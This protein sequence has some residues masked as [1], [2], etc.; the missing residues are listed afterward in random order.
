M[1]KLAQEL[2]AKKCGVLREEEAL[3][4][5]TLQQYLH[6]YKQPLLDQSMEAVLKL[7]EMTALKEE[8]E[9]ET[10]ERQEI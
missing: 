5:L 2:V 6:L 3:D 1:T 7:T 10:E 9:E 8:Q 4:K